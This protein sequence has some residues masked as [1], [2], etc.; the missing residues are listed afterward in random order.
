MQPWDIWISDYKHPN[1]KYRKRCVLAA[2]VGVPNLHAR[3]DLG[4]ADAVSVEILAS[5]SS[6][7]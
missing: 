4:V 6:K 7:I 2:V 3:R 1:L 5:F